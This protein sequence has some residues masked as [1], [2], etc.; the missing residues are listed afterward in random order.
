[1]IAS[2]NVELARRLRAAADQLERQP[3][4]VGAAGALVEGLERLLE[5]GELARAPVARRA[6]AGD[7]QARIWCDGSCS[8]NPGPGGWGAVIDRNGEREEIS[9]ASRD[10][11][12]NIM[13]L[14]AAIEA[15]KRI[16][17]G[18]PAVVATDSRYVVDGITK[19][20][21]AWKRKGWRKA[22][23]KPVLNQEYWVALDALARERKLRW[24]WVEGHAGDPGN[25]RADALANAAR[26]EAS[27]AR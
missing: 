15:L 21:A 10:S 9:G 8:P 19:W 11:T 23:G 17:A 14:T 26:E 6:G 3:R 25:E 5:S 18:S 24:Q 2:S 4:V 16:P 22:D 13:E 1:M 12:N 20:I 7:G 27:R